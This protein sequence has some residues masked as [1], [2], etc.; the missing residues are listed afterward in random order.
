M[1]EGAGTAQGAPVEPQ[2]DRPHVKVERLQGPQGSLPLAIRIPQ[3]SPSILGRVGPGGDRALETSKAWRSRLRLPSRRSP[4]GQLQEHWETLHELSAVVGELGIPILLTEDHRGN[5]GE[6]VKPAEDGAAVSSEA[7]WLLKELGGM[8]QLIRRQPYLPAPGKCS[9]DPG[10]CNSNCP[11]HVLQG[12]PGKGRAPTL[13][14][15]ETSR[16]APANRVCIFSEYTLPGQ[17]RWLVEGRPLSLEQPAWKV[18]AAAYGGDVHSAALLGVQRAGDSAATEGLQGHGAGLLWDLQGTGCGLRTPGT[19]ILSSCRSQHTLVLLGLLSLM[20]FLCFKGSFSVKRFGT[21]LKR[22][23]SPP[24][25]YKP[26]PTQVPVGPSSPAP[27][28]GALWLGT[29][30]R[31]QGHGALQAS[32]HGGSH[33]NSLAHSLPA[34]TA[35]AAGWL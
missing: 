17:L 1:A 16:D 25:G 6:N 26:V 18:P 32:S 21:Q 30:C 7:G 9:L 23:C 11:F 14:Y 24:D 13:C 29:Q 19:R 15:Q 2:W 3:S 33:G 20:L 31:H 10:S 12:E 27:A 5:R 8:K 22:G 4:S 35:V 34:H 28:A